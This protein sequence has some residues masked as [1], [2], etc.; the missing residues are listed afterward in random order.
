MK[1][2]L[3]FSLLILYLFLLFGCTPISLPPSSSVIQPINS[4]ETLPDNGGMNI[5]D[6]N[7]ISIKNTLDT[8]QKISYYMIDYFTYKIHNGIWNPYELFLNKWGDC[9]DFATFGCYIAHFN[10]YET[11]QVS[12]I[13]QGSNGHLIAVYRLDNDQYVYTD[14]QYYIDQDYDYYW[15]TGKEK[16]F[17]SI[18]EIIEY[19]K[20]FWS[21]TPH[22]LIDYKIY[23]WN[24]FY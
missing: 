10:G 21:D 8:P 19:E 5:Y 4:S 11:Y 12:E 18:E 16:Y 9:A 3:I 14:N 24:Y 1:N 22:P 23:P 17:Y 2:K 7:F 13:L 15:E 6:E 20:N